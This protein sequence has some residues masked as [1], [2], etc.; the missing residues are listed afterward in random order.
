MRSRTN[1]VLKN[2][3][4]KKRHGLSAHEGVHLGWALGMGM[5]KNYNCKTISFKLQVAYDFQGIS[6][7]VISIG[8]LEG[9]WSLLLLYS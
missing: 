9:M 6:V 8:Q 7:H 4:V 1:K 2:Q 5:T 3:H